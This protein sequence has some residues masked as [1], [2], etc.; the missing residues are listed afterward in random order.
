ML[1]P[2][3]FKKKKDNK[4]LAF[5]KRYWP[6]LSLALFL[7][8]LFLLLSPYLFRN[9]TEYPEALRA[10]IAWRNFQASFQTA[11]REGCL[12]QRQS[13]ASIWRPYYQKNPALALDHF[14][15]VFA[16]GPEE[17]QAALIKIMA[18]DSQDGS[19]PPLLASVIAD[20]KASAENKRLIVTFFPDAFQDEAWQEQLRAMIADESL[21]LSERIYAV[22]LLASF[23]NTANFKALTALILKD[24]DEDLLFAAI[25]SLSNWPETE[26]SWSEGEIEVLGDL[27]KRS[28]KGQARWRRLWIVN[29]LTKKYPDKTRTLLSS[30]A[31]DESLDAISRG[32]A[33]E[34]LLSDFNIN[35]KTPVP[36]AQ[37]WQEFYETL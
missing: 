2:L 4:T 29:S 6:Y 23:P 10:E 31:S 8:V 9:W 36:A 12:A 35:I 17:L 27:I 34:A 1:M 13:Y 25:R 18:A 22:E 16:D 14:S 33:A 32:L 5:I 30:L 21:S 37:D 7:L 24:T 15:A 26:F 3:E 28:P 20:S 19:L 11:C